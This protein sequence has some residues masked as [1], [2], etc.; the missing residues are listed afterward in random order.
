MIWPAYL[1]LG[2]VTVQRI[3]ELLLAERNTR[4]L[5]ARGAHEAGRR[6]YPLLVA[7][8][9]SWLAA[10]WVTAPG[11]AIHGLALLVFVMLQAARLWVIATL[12]ERWTTRIIVLPGAPLVRR[13]PYRWFAHPNYLV[14]V[15]EIA[16]LPLVFGQLLIAVVFSVLNAVILA[17]RIGE[18]NRA[19]G[20]PA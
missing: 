8:H 17:I 12:G 13:G 9:A 2:L 11:Q 18:E 20:G 7:I 10:L 1:I 16:M 3:A 6:H 14:V 15:A 5:L 19:L 4:R